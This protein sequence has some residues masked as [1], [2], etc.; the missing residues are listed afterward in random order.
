MS[1][2]ASASSVTIAFSLT[3]CAPRLSVALAELIDPAEQDRPFAAGDDAPDDIGE[4]TEL[5]LVEIAKQ[6]VIDHLRMA[7]EPGDRR[8]PARR[9]GEEDAAAIDPARRLLH[10][11][12]A[13]EALHDHRDEGAADA[14]MA[15]DGADRDAPR[16]LQLGD[17]KK[18]PVFRLADAEMAGEA[19][20]QLLQLARHRHEIAQHLAEDAVGAADEQQRARRR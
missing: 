15:R 17:G 14:E 11:A 5:L 2:R 19:G 3:P 7:R 8:P 13:H 4:K 16:P 12:G 20:T 9:Q 18:H 1:F 10:L 6:L